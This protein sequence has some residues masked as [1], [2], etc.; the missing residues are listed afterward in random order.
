[1]P[2]AEEF[3]ALIAL[4]EDT[5]HYMWEWG[6]EYNAAHNK[7]YGLRITQKSTDN[8]VFFPAAGSWEGP[9]FSDSNSFGDYWSSTIG[10][11]FQ[12]MSIHFTIDE[13]I[14]DSGHANTG[15]CHR[16]RGLTIRPVYVE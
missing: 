12:Y 13:G 16:T 9:Y 11:T 10:P 14:D 5:E 4:K 2:T 15:N 8:S 6:Y 7:I 3:E 1:M